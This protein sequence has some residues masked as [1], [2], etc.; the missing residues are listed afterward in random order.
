MP[1]DP[2]DLPKTLTFRPGNYTRMFHYGFGVVVRDLG[3]WRPGFYSEFR[4][5]SREHTGLPWAAIFREVLVLNYI[6]RFQCPFF[7]EQV[8]K[9]DSFPN[10][11]IGKE[12]KWPQ[13]QYFQDPG[14][15]K[16]LEIQYF[17]V[18]RSSEW[19]VFQYVWV[20]TSSKWVVFQYF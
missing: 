12:L 20:P 17:Q 4:C 8:P 9:V 6:P 5:A 19:L 2:N 13:I 11:A 16:W 1:Y 14:F 15:L 7:E 18:P 3:E 10:V